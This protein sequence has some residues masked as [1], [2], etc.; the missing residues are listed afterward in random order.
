MF[1]VTT[2][3]GAR[4]SSGRSAMNA[5]LAPKDP[6]LNP[7]ERKHM[8]LLWSLVDHTARVAINM[9][10]LT[11]L[12]AWQPARQNSQALPTTDNWLSL[13][14]LRSFALSAVTRP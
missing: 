13:R 4:L 5:T 10:L 9:A 8:P 3:R 1:I 7:S 12:F 6:L 14:Y 2:R 11:E